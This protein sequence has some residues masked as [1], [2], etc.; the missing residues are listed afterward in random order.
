MTTSA[1]QAKPIFQPPA[2]GAAKPF[3]QIEVARILSVGA[4]KAIVSIN[5]SVIRNNL[6]HMA[7]IGTI[8]KIV[9]RE[10]IVVAM[11]SSLKIGGMDDEGLRDGCIAHLD[12]LGEIT[13]N[14]T[15]RTT[16]FY[17][18]V[19]SFPVLNEPVFNMSAQ[20]L[21][22]IFNKENEPC[23]EVGKLHQDKSI[24]ARVRIDD[25]LS[26][27]FAIIG[28]T[29]SGKSCTVA[30]VLQAILNQNNKAHVVLFDPHNE[31]SKSFGN[32]AEVIRSNDLDIPLWMF[33]FEEIVELITSEIADH[34]HEEQDVLLRDN[35][36]R[37]Y[38]VH[39]LH[40]SHHQRL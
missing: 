40:N 37:A 16:Q 8:L 27:H 15:T 35:P 33:N 23:I 29:G 17:R 38:S 13:T 36:H 32:M 30:L 26:K 14:P 1:T 31:Y 19:R 4:S 22:L 6:L 21:E 9:T 18:G 20:D 11:V 39:C 5:K 12:I 24:A 7:Q 3:K 2:K 28:S 10:S 34:A 25:L